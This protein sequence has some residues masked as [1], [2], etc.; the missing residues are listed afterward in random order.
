M[1]VHERDARESLKGSYAGRLKLVPCNRQI[2]EML[3]GG[4][5]G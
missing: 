5:R 1:A 2:M 3:R 4:E